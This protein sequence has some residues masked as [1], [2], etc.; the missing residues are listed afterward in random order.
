MKPKFVPTNH[1][2]LIYCLTYQNM[3]FS[4]CVMS[5]LQKSVTKTALSHLIWLTSVLT[6][7]LVSKKNLLWIF[8]ENALVTPFSFSKLQSQN[9]YIVCTH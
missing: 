5:K 9:Y 8:C 4:M 7:V 3:L 6:I 2:N 1:M